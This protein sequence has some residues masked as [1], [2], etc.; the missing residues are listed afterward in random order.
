M[1]FACSRRERLTLRYYIKLVIVVLL[2]HRFLNHNRVLELCHLIVCCIRDTNNKRLKMTTCNKR[3]S[4][5]FLTRRV[6]IQLKN[7]NIQQCEV[8]DERF[9]LLLECK[10]RAAISRI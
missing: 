6:S 1:V 10:A 3:Y 2:R 8:L 5:A 4:N 7:N 9:P